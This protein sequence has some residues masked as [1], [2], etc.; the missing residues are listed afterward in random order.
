MAASELVV[1]LLAELRDLVLCQ[2]R[3]EPRKHQEKL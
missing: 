2:P 3:F 1:G